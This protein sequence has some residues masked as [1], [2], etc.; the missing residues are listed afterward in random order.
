MDLQPNFNNSS[1]STLIGVFSLF[2]CVTCGYL[3]RIYTSN[4]MAHSLVKR[5]DYYSALVVEV[6]TEL[7]SCWEL[8]IP[9]PHHRT[10]KQWSAFPWIRRS[11]SV[12]VHYM[13]NVQTY[14]PELFPLELWKGLFKCL[15]LCFG[16]YYLT[17]IFK[18]FIVL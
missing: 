13:Y 8:F 5:Q 10:V 1:Y 16:Q 15:F 3:Y 6:G 7:K 11:T 18:L 14:V 2:S 4:P 12:V 9:P 17:S